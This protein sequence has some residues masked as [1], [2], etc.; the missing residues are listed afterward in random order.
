MKL[1]L[2]KK[3][4]DETSLLESELNRKCLLASGEKENKISD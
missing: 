3:C 4:Q 1:D 2:I